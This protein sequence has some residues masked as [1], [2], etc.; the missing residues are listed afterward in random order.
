MNFD[1]RYS[2]QIWFFRK[3]SNTENNTNKIES[4]PSDGI[5]IPRSVRFWFLLS[6]EIPSIIC[7]IF[8]LGHFLFYRALRHALYNHV[9]IIFLSINFI[10]QLTGIPWT[11]NYYRIGRVWP[12]TE[13][14][15][16]V[17]VFVDEALYIT[18]TLLFAW[19]TAERHILIFHYQL[20]ST[21]IKRIFIH[22]FPIGFVSLYCLCYS[23]IVI[24]FPP[25]ENKFDYTSIVCGSP[26]CYYENGV[27][28]LWDAIV[29]HIIP[30]FIIISCSVT[31]LG[32]I[33]YQKKRVRQPIRW[34]KH[35][36]MAIQLLSI[37]VLYLVL[38][39]PDILLDFVYLCGISKDVGASF[40]LYANFFSYYG[41]L[42]LPFV[43][44]GSLPN[45][46]RKIKRIFLCRRRERRAI[47]PQI[48]RVSQTA[49]DQS[50]RRQTLIG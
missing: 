17:W 27:V 3:I 6:F 16:M 24:V 20:V 26:L 10:I 33:L 43:C 38:Y 30:T 5:A 4:S 14:F 41:N 7:S 48:F 36:K 22:Y 11:L 34:R 42:L 40:L 46:K 35:R 13:T 47:A 12:A 28:A 39:I 31:L 19:A 50:A 25:C 23:F 9:I 8:V 21:R 49:Y 32:R 45:L 2:H 18:K 29:N 37:S 1:R 15:C 44:A